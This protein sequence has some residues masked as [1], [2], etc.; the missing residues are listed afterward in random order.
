MRKYTKGPWRVEKRTTPGEFVTTTHIVSADGS[1][2]ANVGPCDIDK[3]APL[4][5]ASP[6][7]LEALDECDTAFTVLN[8]NSDEPMNPQARQAMRSAWE[9]TQ[10]ALAKA[11]GRVD[12]FKEEEES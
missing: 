12:M 7:L 8:I 1:H 4:I 10:A 5:A 3:N 9:K 2:I 11:L 6:D